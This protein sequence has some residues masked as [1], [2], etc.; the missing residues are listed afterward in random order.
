MG[1]EGEALKLYMREYMREY[2]RKKKNIDPSRYKR[3]LKPGENY[4][5][6][7]RFGTYEAYIED[8]RKKQRERYVKKEKYTCEVCDCSVFCASRERHENS[9]KHQFTLK[10]LQRFQKKDE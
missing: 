9:K 4:G 1:L 2:H 3:C 5:I 6:L 10:V 8:I 7:S